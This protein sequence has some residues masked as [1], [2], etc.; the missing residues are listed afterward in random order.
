LIVD[1]LKP[2]PVIVDDVQACS[3]LSFYIYYDI[4]DIDMFE[5][6]QQMHIVDK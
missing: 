4:E 3:D 1:T 5:E 2:T 6:I